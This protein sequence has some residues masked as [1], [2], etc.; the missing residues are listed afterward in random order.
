M[1][2][3]NALS[4]EEAYAELAKGG[5][6]TRA[7]E[8]ARDEDLGDSG[9]VTS[10]VCIEAGTMGQADLVAR[11]AGV[12]AG[13]AALPE[14]IRVFG[15]RVELRARTRDGST[16]ERG[17]VLAELSG[18]MRDLLALERTALNFV[19]RL[20]GVAT[21]TDAFVKAVAGTRAGIY[22]T[23]KTTPGLRVLEKYAVR[24]GGGRCHRIG[25]FDALL[26]K[27]NHLA[28]VTVAELAGTVK[29]ASRKARER[30]PG[31]KFVE[32][33]VDSLEQLEAVLTLERGVVDVVLLDN[34]APA[35]MRQAVAMRDA[36]RSRP[37]LEASGG[38]RLETVAE[39]ART[40]VER[41]SAGALTHS[42][43]ALDVALDVR[44]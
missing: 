24:C 9:D 18:E 44:A 12:I 5:L 32:V 13:L 35:V 7:L 26:V 23:R 34:M 29:E 25:L 20:S 27:D 43:V 15:A 33:E 40:G 37:E 10:A 2:E 21:L 28:G 19:G 6:V 14:L 38:V 41:I 17:A 4:L 30:W 42:A 8:L 22:D 31:M 39:I 1:R 36:S 16:I 3:V 11:R